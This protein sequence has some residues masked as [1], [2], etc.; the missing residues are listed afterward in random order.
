[1]F[2]SGL[3]PYSGSQK[4]GG[5][6]TGPKV[7]GPP[8]GVDKGDM[9]FIVVESGVQMSVTLFPGDA[10]RTKPFYT[11]SFVSDVSFP[12]GVYKGSWNT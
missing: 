4:Y 3:G 7:H 8:N 2:I 5:M 1:M 10:D 12:A 11:G 9:W 6:G